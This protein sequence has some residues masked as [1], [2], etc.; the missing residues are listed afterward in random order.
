MV[1][2]KLGNSHTSAATLPRPHQGQKKVPVKSENT[3]VNPYPTQHQS[4]R[5]TAATS[6]DSLSKVRR[7]SIRSAA[8]PI[9][10]R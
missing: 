7:V 3:M 6:A 5:P 4:P 9:A 10:R 8:A 2:H 1:G